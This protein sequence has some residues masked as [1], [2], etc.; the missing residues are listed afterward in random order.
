MLDTNIEMKTF[1]KLRKITKNWKKSKKS[2]NQ[3]IIKKN[4]WYF[5]IL[6]KMSRN[7]W[8]KKDTSAISKSLA[9][10]ILVVI[11]SF[12]RVN[13]NFTFPTAGKQASLIKFLQL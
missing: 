7:S 11:F 8:D 5:M 1:H 2:K 4:S 3:K 12:P 6:F 10:G 9:L 13:C